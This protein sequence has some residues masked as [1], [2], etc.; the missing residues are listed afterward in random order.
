MRRCQKLKWI[1]GGIF[2]IDIWNLTIYSCLINRSRSYIP[3]CH[4][5]RRAFSRGAFAV[6]SP[7][8]RLLLCGVSAPKQSGSVMSPFTLESLWMQPRAADAFMRLHVPPPILWWLWCP[9]WS[10]SICTHVIVVMI[11]TRA[12]DRSTLP[13]SA[14]L[15]LAALHLGCCLRGGPS[16]D[17]YT[18]VRCTR[19]EPR[20][21]ELAA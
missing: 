10:G 21:S 5:C 7:L 15:E 4:F 2:N 1:N 20:W 11:H 18:D 9:R 12:A 14:F 17:V 16:T 3:V 8:S 6:W 13:V 19:S